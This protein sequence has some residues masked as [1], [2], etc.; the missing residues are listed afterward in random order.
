MA[1]PAW[2]AE[3]LA[4]E[5]TRLGTRALRPEAYFD[6]VSARLRRAVP[7]Q[8][9]CWHTLDPETRLLTSEAPG[10]LVRSGVFS[11]QTAPAAGQAVVNSEYI[12]EDVNT[13]AALSR[14]RT[15]VGILSDATR[16][17]R[18]RSARYRDVLAPSGI[19]S[20]TAL[21]GRGTLEGCW[22]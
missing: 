3:R 16:G 17:R 7:S 21:S 18:E 1:R 9:N 22:P 19:H 8:A 4:D 2:S 20:W 14:R 13:F 15:T 12:V 5:L 10:E 6:E 11:A